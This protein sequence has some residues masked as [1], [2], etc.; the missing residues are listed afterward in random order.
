ADLTQILVERGPLLGRPRESFQSA[1]VPALAPLPGLRDFH[2]VQCLPGA[3]SGHHRRPMTTTI[4]AR[5]LP[6]HSAASPDPESVAVE[7]R[8]AVDGSG[9]APAL[10]EL[11]RNVS[12]ARGPT[13]SARI[14][15]ADRRSS[16]ARGSRGRRPGRNRA[17]GAPLARTAVGVQPT[18]LRPVS[19][20]VG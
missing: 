6:P 11:A 20:V 1:R 10:R 14:G 12:C 19:V 5:I 18:G 4:H 15:A 9:Q 2:T 13:G 3:A 8:N 16:G 7:P 17:A